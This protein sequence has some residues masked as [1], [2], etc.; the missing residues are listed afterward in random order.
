MSAELE[1]L[2]ERIRTELA[3]LEQVLRRTEAGWQ[4]AE[5]SGDDYYLDGVALNLH[6]LCNGLERVPL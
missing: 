3:E 6:G 4:R 5:R 1:Q 2:G